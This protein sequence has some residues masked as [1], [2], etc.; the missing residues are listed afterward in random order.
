M[1]AETCSH[2]GLKCNYF[3]RTCDVGGSIKFKQS[4]EGYESLFHVCYFFSCDLEIFNKIIG[5]QPGVICKP[6]NTAKQIQK[7]QCLLTLSGGTEKIKNAVAATGV[8]DTLTM[9]IVNYTLDMGKKLQKTVEG[10]VKIPEAEIW[11]MSWKVY[12][13]RYPLTC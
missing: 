5:L 7:Q 12:Y 1:Q 9:V 3:C 10:K 8:K 6:E 11:R 13:K 2:V 4:D